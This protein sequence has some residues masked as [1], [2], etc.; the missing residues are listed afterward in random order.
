[1]II[2]LS[3]IHSL[4]LCHIYSAIEVPAYYG[5][6][7]VITARMKILWFRLKANF[8]SSQEGKQRSSFSAPTECQSPACSPWHVQFSRDK[9]QVAPLWCHWFTTVLKCNVRR[10]FPCHAIW[11]D[12]CK[13]G[14]NGE[15]DLNGFWC[16]W[17]Q[18]LMLRNSTAG[19]GGE[20]KREK[21]DRLRWKKEKRRQKVFG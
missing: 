20:W 7:I 2:K 17:R 14:G 13:C 18:L 6:T 15:L 19:K 16:R 11:H 12:G 10:S 21:G 9:P 5:A 1:M 4:S 3:L 8:T